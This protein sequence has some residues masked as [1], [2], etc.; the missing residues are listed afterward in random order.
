MKLKRTPKDF[1]KNKLIFEKLCLTL[2]IYQ[3]IIFNLPYLKHAE[4]INLIAHNTIKFTLSTLYQKMKYTQTEVDAELK[5]QQVNI[6]FDVL[7]RAL[8]DIYS[9]I[10]NPPTKP[11][12]IYY[13]ENY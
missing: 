5:A 2:L 12:T 4:E 11:N 1:K 9:V 13:F 10:N 6:N 8:T 7:N 3:Q